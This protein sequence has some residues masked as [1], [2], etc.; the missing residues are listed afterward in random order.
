MARTFDSSHVGIKACTLINDRV[1]SETILT[2]TEDFDQVILI[3]VSLAIAA[4]LI[5]MLIGLY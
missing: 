4:V 1:K 5:S 3:G 2:I